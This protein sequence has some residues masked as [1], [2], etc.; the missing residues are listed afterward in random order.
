MKVGIIVDELS[1]NSGIG[2]YVNELITGLNKKGIYAERVFVKKIDRPYGDVINHVFRLPYT[3]LKTSSKYDI[4]HA[5]TPI[6]GLSCIFIK[7]SPK[8]VTYHD[9]T[10][11]LYND[12]GSKLHVKISS[13]LFLKVGKYCDRIISVSSQTKEEIVEHIEIPD[14]KITVVNLGID[15]RFKPIN[16]DERDYYIIGYLGALVKRKSV[17]FL[18]NSFHLLKRNHPE[19]NIKLVIWGEKNFEYHNLIE[20]AK[21]LNISVEFMGIASEKNIVEI[22]NSFDIFVLPSMWEGFA[23]PILEAQK[24]GIPVIVRENAHIPYEVRKYCLISGSEEDL[25]EKLYLYLTNPILREETIRNGFNYSK[26]FTWNKMVDETITVYND[27]LSKYPIK[28]R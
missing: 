3:V 24:C 21:Q 9:L 20:L 10:S 14:E 11:F 6:T 5:T 13:S 26:K 4:L 25:A 28:K 8:V 7:K 16:R 27:V 12:S 23:L 18:I 22:Y 2:R 17:D 15:D 19:I 1:F